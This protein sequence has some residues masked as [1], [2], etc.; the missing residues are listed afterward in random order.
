MSGGTDVGPPMRI[1]DL[2][3]RQAVH[4]H[5][6]R[7]GDPLWRLLREL[8]VRRDVGDRLGDPP[9]AGE[10]VREDRARTRT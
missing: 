7:P 2:D 9:G 10:P 3:L 8:Q 6:A 4:A 5:G 1:R